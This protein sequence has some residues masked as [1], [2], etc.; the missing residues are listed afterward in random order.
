MRV[1]VGMSAPAVTYGPLTRTDADSLL[2]TGVA[3]SRRRELY[4]LSGGN[5]LYLTE[6]ARG[7][8]EPDTDPFQRELAALG[9]AELTLLRAAAVAGEDV[10]L[11]MLAATADLPPDD[12][13]TALSA[14]AARD[15]LRP[16]TVEPARSVMEERGIGRSQ[17]RRD[18]GV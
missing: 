8:D 7:D 16:R 18:R 3:A 5:P 12:A 17:R 15:L 2:G 11:G 4:Q 6:L 13:R 9:P 14:L 1:E 10:D